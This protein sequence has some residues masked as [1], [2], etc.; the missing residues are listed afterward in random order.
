MQLRDEADPVTTLLVH[1][2]NGLGGELHMP[3]RPYQTR[4]DRPGRAAF[5]RPVPRREAEF[6]DRRQVRNDIAEA[7]VAHIVLEIEQ[8]VLDRPTPF[9]RL[10]LITGSRD[11]ISDSAGDGE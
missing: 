5:T 11:E 8:A 1:R 6:D 7:L 3:S 10:G 9:D 4:V 2:K